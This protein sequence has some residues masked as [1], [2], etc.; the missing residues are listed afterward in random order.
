MST[1]ARL[2]SASPR[3]APRKRRRPSRRRATAQA[4]KAA[5]VDPSI[6]D[7][8]GVY[9]DMKKEELEKATA[10]AGLKNAGGGGPKRPGA[11]YAGGARTNA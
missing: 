8:D 3:R 11:R 7:Y 6:Y 2:L 9:D 5:Q 10:R 4:A 1:D